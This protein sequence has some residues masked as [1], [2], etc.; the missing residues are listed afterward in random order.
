MKRFRRGLAMMGLLAAGVLGAACTPLDSDTLQLSGRLARSLLGQ[1]QKVTREQAAAVEYASI[2][3]AIGSDDQTM[4]VLGT[5]TGSEQDW[6]SSNEAMIATRNGR[7]VATAGLPHNLGR[8]N[9]LAG[10]AGDGKAPLV[11]GRKYKLLYDLPEFR[12]FSVAVEC[13]ASAANDETIEILG[14][15]IQTRHVTESCDSGELGWS[16]ENEFWLDK[17][18]GFVWRSVQAVNPKMSAITVEVLRPNE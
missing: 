4:L 17:D 6:F 13:E 9:A 2:G 1:Q 14:A 15:Q 16:F 3:V 18:T 8:V 7:I 10:E 12:L 11:P 5:D